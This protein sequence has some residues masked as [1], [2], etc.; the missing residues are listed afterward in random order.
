MKQAIFGCFT[1]SIAAAVYRGI[2]IKTFSG[3]GI[4]SVLCFYAVLLGTSRR[5]GRAKVGRDKVL[6]RAGM[7]R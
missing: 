1:A 7:R 5:Q 4:T 3:D 2:S 6:R